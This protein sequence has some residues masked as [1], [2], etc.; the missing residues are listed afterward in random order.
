MRRL[1]PKG[2]CALRSSWGPKN[3]TVV[4]G[5]DAQMAKRYSA[6]CRLR[7]V[8][9]YAFARPNLSRQRDFFGARLSVTQEDASWSKY[10]IHSDIHRFFLPISPASKAVPMASAAARMGSSARCAY[11]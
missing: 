6:S 9:I 10:L 8:S 5:D 1:K 11:R 4:A 3:D 7:Q 2:H